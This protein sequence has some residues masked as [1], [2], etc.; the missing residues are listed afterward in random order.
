MIEGES[1]NLFIPNILKYLINTFYLTLK[2]CNEIKNDYEI[3]KRNNK[4]NI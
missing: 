4:N 3:W 2:E 1:L